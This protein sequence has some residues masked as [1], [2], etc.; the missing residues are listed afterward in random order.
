MAINTK[1]QVMFLT[2]VAS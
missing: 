2:K 1:T